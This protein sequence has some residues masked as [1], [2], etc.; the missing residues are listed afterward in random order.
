MLLPT[1]VTNR[2]KF[3][4]RTALGAGSVLFLPGL[5]TSCADHRIPDPSTPGTP[6]VTSPV[7]GDGYLSDINDDA[8]T[9]VVGGLSLIP[10][11]GGLLSALTSLFWPGTDVWSQV[12]GQVEALVDKEIDNAIY[13][14]VDAKLKGLKKDIQSYL[15]QVKISSGSDMFN[16]WYT[17][18]DFFNT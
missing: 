5:L 16:T 18:Q 13:G 12:K 1:S 8:K 17:T 10:E 4:E 2:R 9:I 3:L 11:V 14:S 6:G 15:D 7:V